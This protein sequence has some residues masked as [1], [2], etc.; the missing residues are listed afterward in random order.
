VLRKN[1]LTGKAELLFTAKIGWRP[2]NF[3]VARYPGAIKLCRCTHVDLREHDE[4]SRPG[5]TLHTVSGGAP[6]GI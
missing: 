3:Q 4:S 6:M 5:H 1:Q 2:A